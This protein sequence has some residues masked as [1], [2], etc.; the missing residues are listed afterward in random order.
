MN[1]ANFLDT[2]CNKF[3]HKAAIGFK[4]DK[5]WKD[6]SWRDL[7]RMIFKTA[8]A[9]K[10]AGVNKGDRVGIYSDN[11]AEWIV[12]DLA[13]LCIGAITVP[14]YATT[15]A[16]Q[17]NYILTDAGINVIMVGNQEQ[18]D[19]VYKMMENGFPI[20]TIVVSK[21][22]V[23][24]KKERTVFLEDFIVDKP[25]SLEIVELKKEEV[26]TVIYTSGTT[27]VPKGVVLTHGNFSDAIEAHFSFFK[28]KDFQ[29]ESSLAFLPLS[30]VFE[31]S[32]TLLCLVGGAKVS[33]L[34]NTK[35]IATAL[36]EVK[37]TMMC[38]VPRFYQ[39]IYAG[40]NEMIA[41]G[42][43][44]KRALF[45]KAMSIGEQVNE[46]KRKEERVPFG[47]IIRYG[48][49]KKL[50]FKKI[51]QRLGGR[52]W[53][54][55]CG[56][57]SISADV[58][59]FFS[60]MGIHI[61]VG[62][63][64]TETTATLTAFPFT[65]FKHGSAGIPLGDTKIRIS[66][67]GEVEAMG[68]GIMKEYYG[69]PEETASVFTSDGWFKTGDKG[70]LDSDGHLFITDRIK[71]LMK[72]ANGKY[73]APQPIENTLS[74]NQYID[75][76]ILV[77][78]DKPFV[79][80]LIVPNFLALET[81]FPEVKAGEINWDDFLMKEDIKAFY[82]QIIDSLQTDFSE[83]EKVRKFTL[84]PK[85]FEIATGEITPTLKIKRDVVLAKY[86]DAVDKMY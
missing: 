4:K 23:W 57:A 53:F 71:D 54:M 24:T 21:K 59:R 1:I 35:Q 7:R 46:L 65:G 37:P 29:N 55:P 2:N 17:V 82:Q 50:V 8:N 62:Y 22:K 51:H 32:W 10:D 18:Y 79:S 67:H 60:S 73:I 85:E 42:S 49:F 39:K 44:V 28:F 68:P 61:T 34:E 41:E 80:A 36:T 40:I 38:A 31:R 77:A 5:E 69:K 26:A 83:Y 86:K 66:S 78:E 63:G 47:L 25:E 64:L 33:F 81:K 74:N 45:N 27:G 76:V 3:A 58:T 16:D 52:L 13:T 70:H 19:T 43:G 30:H 12:F 20:S 15:Q 75:Q 48:I 11:S 9:L 56:G 72:T 6:L 14:L 84:M